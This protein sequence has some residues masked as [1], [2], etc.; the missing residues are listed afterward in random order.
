LN[1][2]IQKYHLL[3]PFIDQV[4]DALS[5]KNFFSFLDGY[6]GYKK[7]KITPEDQ[8]K[9]T[10]TCVWSTFA[11]QFLPFG[12]C[13]VA[14]TFQWVVLGIFLDLVNDSLE[15]YMNDFM[16]HGDTFD[17]ALANIQKLFKCCKQT[18]L[19]L[20]PKKCHMMMD[21]G[22]VLGYYISFTGI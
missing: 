22:V 13:N 3:S 15:I 12:I 6:N 21:E 19:S 2:D 20:S 9:T 11:Y 17:M 16:S 18:H 8:N 14:T 4:L 7:I 5:G 1:K 10:F